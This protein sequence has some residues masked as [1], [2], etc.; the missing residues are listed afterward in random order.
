[1]PKQTYLYVFVTSNKPDV[2]I[3][4]IR[5]CIEH[6]SNLNQRI[7]F[8]SIY[9]DKDKKDSM[10]AYIESVIDLVKKRLTVLSRGQYPKKGQLEDIKIEKYQKNKYLNAVKNYEFVAEPF[11]YNELEEELKKAIEENCVFDATGFQ[12]DY[13]VDV[14]T[15]LHL[16]NNANLHYFKLK[17]LKDRTYDDQELIHNLHLGND[18]D[19]EN[20]SE[21]DYTESTIVKSIKD[22]EGLKEQRTKVNYL[23]EEYANS[24]SSIWIKVIRFILLV[25]LVIFLVKLYQKR[26]DWNAIEPYTFIFLGP[27]GLWILN[28]L[29]GIIGNNL[30]DALNFDNIQSWIKKKQIKRIEKKLIKHETEHK[31]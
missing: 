24:V 6:F 28:L 13:L 17:T 19:F 4:P 18:Y 12:K 15:I 1:M 29:N 3:N 2:Y 22:I 27:I 30:K 9:E 23:K 7:K 31:S 16:L 10:K 21:S 8:V 5:H 26:G 25:P 14:Y 20:I 11:L